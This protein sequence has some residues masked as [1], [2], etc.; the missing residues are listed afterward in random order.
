[1]KMTDFLLNE[2]GDT[3]T[4][5]TGSSDKVVIPEGIT[6]LGKQSFFMSRIRE[7]ELPRGVKYLKE[8]C[9]WN[10]FLLSKVKLPDTLKI[11][12]K[13]AFRTCMSLFEL[14]LPKS[15][16]KIAVGA[17]YK[18]G[19]KKVYY[20]GT[21]AEWDK[22]QIEDG[23]VE[24][25]GE[26]QFF[27]N[28]DFLNAIVEFCGESSVSSTIS[29]TKSTI[30]F[31]ESLNHYHLPKGYREYF[32]KETGMP[33]GTLE[34]C[35]R[36]FDE[37]TDEDREDYL[38]S[39]QD[40]YGMIDFVKRTEYGEYFSCGLIAQCL[41]EGY[42][43]TK[44]CELMHFWGKRFIYTKETVGCAHYFR[45]LFEHR[46]VDRMTLCCY[47]ILLQCGDDQMISLAN[48]INSLLLLNSE[49]N[50]D[51]EEI[52][53]NLDEDILNQGL[54]EAIYQNEFENYIF[55]YAVKKWAGYSIEE[56]DLRTCQEFCEKMGAPNVYNIIENTQNTYD[57]VIDDEYAILEGCI[58]V[59]DFSVWKEFWMS[60]LY[61]YTTMYKNNDFIFINPIFNV[62]QER[63]WYTEQLKDMAIVLVLRYFSSKQKGKLHEQE[64]TENTYRN[65]VEY[66]KSNGTY[67][68]FPLLGSMPSDEVVEECIFRGELGS[69]FKGI[70]KTS[71]PKTKKSL[72]SLTRAKDVNNIKT[73]L[74]TAKENE[75]YGEYVYLSY[76]LA[77]Q[78]QAYDS[79]ELDQVCN[80]I[81]IPF[82]SSC[83]T[84]QAKKIPQFALTYTGVPKD[85]ELA[86]QRIFSMYEAADFEEWNEFWIKVFYEFAGK[87]LNGC[88]YPFANKLASIFKK[89]DDKYPQYETYN[90]EVFSLMH[91]LIE[92]TAYIGDEEKHKA[93]TEHR[94][95][96]QRQLFIA[97]FNVFPD[98]S[99]QEM[100]DCI[101]HAV[102]FDATEFELLDKLGTCAENISNGYHLELELENGSSKDNNTFVYSQIVSIEVESDVSNV[103]FLEMGISSFSNMIRGGLVATLS[104]T[105]TSV[106]IEGCISL[107]SKEKDFFISAVI[108]IP[109]A[110][111]EGK[112]TSV[113]VKVKSFD[114]IDKYLVLDLDFILTLS[115]GDDDD[116]VDEY[117]DDDEIDWDALL[118]YDGK[119][120]VFVKF[121]GRSGYYYNYDGKISVGDSVNV[122]GKLS[123]QV[124]IVS[125]IAPWNDLPY[126]QMVTEVIKKTVAPPTQTTVGST[127]NVVA[128]STTQSASTSSL[129]T[130]TA[131]PSQ[132][133]S[134]TSTV[135]VVDNRPTET[136]KKISKKTV[137]SIAILAL[138]LV[139]V[140]VVAIASSIAKERELNTRPDSPLNVRVEGDTVYWDIVEGA[141]WYYVH[142]ANYEYTSYSNSYKLPYLKGEAYSISVS[143]YDTDKNEGSRE[144]SLSTVLTYTPK[145]YTITYHN[146]KPGKSNQVDKYRPNTFVSM[147]YSLGYSLMYG[148]EEKYFYGWF[149]DSSCTIPFEKQDDIFKITSNI[150]VYGKWDNYY[151]EI[152]NGVLLS[153]K[154][155]Q[156]KFTIPSNVNV[157]GEGAFKNN[158]KLTEIIIGTNVKRIE[159]YAFSGCSNLSKIVFSGNGLIKIG[160]RAFANC[161]L[162]KEITLPNSVTEIGS[163][164]FYGCTGIT[165]IATPVLNITMSEVFGASTGTQKNFAPNLR[166]IIILQP[167][168]SLPSFAF[169]DFDLLTK[170]VIPQSVVSMGYSVFSDCNQVLVY[171]SR[172]Y[173]P[174]GWN[175]NWN[176]NN[177]PVVW[178]YTGTVRTYKFV[179]NGGTAVRNIT[180][181]V[182]TV[183]PTTTRDGAE[184]C[185][186][187]DNS[188]FEGSPIVTPY[189]GNKTT[190]YAKWLV[191]DGRSFDTAY[192]IDAGTSYTYSWRYSCTAT[193]KMYFQFTVP[194]RFSFLE[195]FSIDVSG[196][197]HS[198]YS[199]ITYSVY[200]GNKNYLSYT[201][202][203]GR[204]TVTGGVTYYIVVN[205]TNGETISIVISDY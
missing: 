47:R 51:I 193:G 128:P 121:P 15:V 52:F 140:L 7:I 190:L 191:R 186:W 22:I 95:Q 89:R 113:E 155:S 167:C 175:A 31:K 185:G 144:S 174:S 179:V 18:S 131:Y 54:Q 129:S 93:Y 84:I 12:G 36:C 83:D 200:D 19:L 158:Q 66:A 145:S 123:G 55:L 69:L 108:D 187:Y 122:S 120:S 48:A 42:L 82:L 170:V 86:L 162:L 25:G 6:T 8:K 161:P 57:T 72:E 62:I 189:A 40:P 137:L 24:T 199:P 133:N 97:T 183:L 172:T 20:L 41:S 75:K 27:S 65:L 166:E 50:V 3:I 23:M 105:Y 44:D 118:V 182:L 168:K 143:A 188:A 17:F 181:D 107:D 173:A 61:K 5:Y 71:K 77:K 110:E 169:E 178:G 106:Q 111:I 53:E 73:A 112:D 101:Y 37:I 192:I 70:R 91:C 124:G 9:F 163:G 195:L 28:T 176:Y 98:M 2:K 139:I 156:S 201:V 64:N 100:S 146:Y 34:L 68:N 127:L 26:D 152:N 90:A 109:Y 204:Y 43:Q 194:T 135:S 153:A 39:D 32:Y 104:D 198:Y 30:Q 80:R 29:K 33:D 81:E 102:Y 78:G 76:L 99:E 147:P 151:L 63:S 103:A 134:V 10:S 92:T 35:C 157:I 94:A 14:T 171:T 160:Q 165:K 87:E 114:R 96:M 126:M 79:N 21:K 60:L 154:I 88:L 46:I 149:T 56:D 1:M 67:K 177:R 115:D 164:A 159:G 142:A 132:K 58:E 119:C 205:A 141:E 11:I 125:R 184:F 148:G 197:K 116:Y 130:S 13:D 196:N 85:K 59:H 16:T 45:Y 4:T 202:S 203:E 138:I 49:G 38:R 74:Q 150:V 117:D 136:Q 180:T